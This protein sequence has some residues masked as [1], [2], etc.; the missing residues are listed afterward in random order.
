MGRLQPPAI[1]LF[2][3]NSWENRS[4]DREQAHLR[5]GMR[6]AGYAYAMTDLLLKGDSHDSDN[7]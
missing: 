6:L 1:E 4:L 5:V 2:K 3:R 7:A